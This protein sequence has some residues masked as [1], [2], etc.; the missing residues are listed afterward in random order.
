MISFFNSRAGEYI[1]GRTRS[2]NLESSAS[3]LG[4]ATRP[5]GFRPFSRRVALRRE[6]QLLRL[7]FSSARAK[8]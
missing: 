7:Q 3:F 4:G 8:T 2:W 1:I 6:E 5:A